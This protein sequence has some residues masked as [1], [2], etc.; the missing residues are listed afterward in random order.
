MLDPA[1]LTVGQRVWIVYRNRNPHT[2]VRGTVLDVQSDAVKVQSDKS[3][4]AVHVSFDNIAQIGTVDTTPMAVKPD[5]LIAFRPSATRAKWAMGLVG[6]VVATLVL[7]LG[8]LAQG[9]GLFSDLASVSEYQALQW[10]RASEGATGFYILAMIGSVIA[11]LSWLSRAVDNVPSLEGGTPIRSPQGAI[12]WWF[13]PLA[14]FFVPYQIVA[15]LWRRMATSPAGRGTAIVVAW[16]VLWIA[17]SIG[18]RILGAALDTVTTIDAFLDVMTLIGLTLVSQ[19]IAGVLL[20]RIIWQI[21]KDVVVRAAAQTAEAS[22][23]TVAAVPP[24][25]GVPAGLAAT[26][27]PTQ[28]PAYT[29][30][31]GSA[32]FTY[33]PSC[34]AMRVVGMRFC[35]ACGTN[36]DALLPQT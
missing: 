27:P 26:Q 36:L 8:V 34:G 1:A 32:G 24:S 33:C 12:G 18:G 16:W 29:S 10:Q 9:I 35:G 23:A 22:S 2:G 21:E 28:V 4:A 31:V 14:N 5:G 7:E 11:F 30:D 6:V 15:D 17:S 25:A 3:G 13:V 19:I 20:I